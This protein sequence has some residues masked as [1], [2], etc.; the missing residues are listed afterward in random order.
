MGVN[1]TGQDLVICVETLENAGKQEIAVPGDF[2]LKGTKGEFHSC[3]P[4]VF[5]KCYEE[6]KMSKVPNI[7]LDEGD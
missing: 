6:I 1:E 7:Y 2:I 4:D 5:E 3:K